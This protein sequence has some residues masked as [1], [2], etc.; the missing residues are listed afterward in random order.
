MTTLE[1][2]T[3]SEGFRICLLCANAD[4]ARDALAYTAVLFDGGGNGIASRSA[5][6]M[7]MILPSVWTCG[8]SWPVWLLL[9]TFWA[10]LGAD[11]RYG[12]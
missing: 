12:G 4:P 8:S 1:D 11:G 2:Q 9:R 7:P 10:A 5:A 3:Y 6:P